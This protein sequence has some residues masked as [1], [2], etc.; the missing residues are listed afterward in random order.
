MQ[1]QGEF[2][3]KKL[4]LVSL[5][6]VRLRLK[7]PMVL[8]FQSPFIDP[9]Q[10][11][12]S[13]YRAPNC[14]AGIP[15]IVNPAVPRNDRLIIPTHVFKVFAYQRAV[16]PAAPNN[17]EVLAYL[18]ANADVGAVGTAPFRVHYGD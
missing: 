5:L 15:R 8:K 1:T 9:K 2:S 6:F 10:F 13:L 12:F 3:F 11:L 18:F 4:F 14:L 7:N 17:G 16:G